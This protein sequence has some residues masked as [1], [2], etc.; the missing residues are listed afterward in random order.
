[1]N[2]VENYENLFLV[3]K[4]KILKNAIE[5]CAGSLIYTY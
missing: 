5:K 4:K 2:S 3:K 1:M